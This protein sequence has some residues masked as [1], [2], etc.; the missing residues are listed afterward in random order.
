MI[1][2]VFVPKQA[3]GAN[4]VYFD[5]F[6]PS[7]S[8]LRFTLLQ[9]LPIVSGAVA[10]SGTVGVDLLLTR[11]TA[12]GTGGTAAT[13][14]GTALDAMTICAHDNA[15]PLTANDITGR[16]TPTG[17]ATGGAV[18]SWRS[19]FTEETN[20]AT[21][22]LQPDLARCDYSDI[23]GIVIPKNS[24]LRVIQG[25]VASVGNIGFDLIIASERL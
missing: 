14:S 16:L 13:Y 11:T 5:L 4:L 15:Q 9:C 12:V 21:Y 19:Y 8:A 17:G 20:V 2:R 7:T 23:P 1:H 10:V 3:V 18:L 6:V 25:A 22:I 24:G